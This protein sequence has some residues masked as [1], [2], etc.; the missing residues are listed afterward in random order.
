M[1][2]IHLSLVGVFAVA[3]LAMAAE[4]SLSVGDPVPAFNVRD[5]TGPNKG[6]TLCYRCKFGDRPVVTIF[7]RDT[8]ENVVAL[9]KDI[10][11]QVAKN[12]DK[13][14]A[15]FV[16]VLTNDADATEAKLAEIAKKEG[17]KHVPLTVIEGDAG[18]D[19]YGVKEDAETTVMM[20]VDGELKVNE[21]FGKGKLSKDAVKTVSAET[22][23]ILN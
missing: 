21:A 13:K 14:M 7:T 16:V 22:K 12:S 17:I 9:V 20:W 3:G 18:P 11:A 2:M 8:N 23:K 19:G 5:I 15:S 1:K 4:K 10:D 6:K